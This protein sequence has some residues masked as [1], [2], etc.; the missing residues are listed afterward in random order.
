M[1][2]KVISS[3][4]TTR[5]SKYNVNQREQAILLMSKQVK[6]DG[7]ISSIEFGFNNLGQISIE[8]KIDI[9]YSIY[10]IY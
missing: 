2:K 4:A 5:I 8:V 10:K 3:G 9:N 1:K 6:E 7:F